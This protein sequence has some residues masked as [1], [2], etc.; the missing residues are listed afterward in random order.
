VARGGRR[1][2]QRRAQCARG[3]AGGGGGCSRRRRRPAQR[4]PEARRA[5]PSAAGRS[6]AAGWREGVCSVLPG[7]LSTPLPGFVFQ[8]VSVVTVR[9]RQVGAGRGSDAAGPGPGRYA[10]KGRGGREFGVIAFAG[11]GEVFNVREPRA[12]CGRACGA[13][14]GFCRGRLRGSPIWG[15]APNS[16]CAPRRSSVRF[17]VACRQGAGGTTDGERRSRAELGSELQTLL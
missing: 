10:R 5:R 11:A 16:T 8:A 3:G 12:R 14:V 2:R 17:G 9:G 13:G 7:G 6:V 1:C 4:G 15:S